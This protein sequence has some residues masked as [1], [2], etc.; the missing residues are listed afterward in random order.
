MPLIKCICSAAITEEDWGF[1]QE[2]VGNDS[3]DRDQVT[4]LS[5]ET[6]QLSSK[7][8]E[9]EEITSRAEKKMQLNIKL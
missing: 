6:Y 5:F 8:E 1:I 4:V 9:I 7:F 3:M 2:V